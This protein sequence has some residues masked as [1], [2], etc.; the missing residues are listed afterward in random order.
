MKRL[1]I[2]I[3]IFIFI[4]VLGRSLI[5]SNQVSSWEKPLQ[6]AVYPI[7]IDNDK[8]TSQYIR[9]LKQKRFQ[10]IERFLSKE[11]KRYQQKSFQPV[12]FNM[13]P[14]LKESPPPAPRK[15]NVF[16]IMW[17][18]L[19]MRYWMHQLESEYDMFPA[20]ISVFVQYYNPKKHPILEHSVGLKKGMFSIIHAYASKKYGA[21]NNVI[22]AH[23][24]LHTVGATDKY[25][26]S[27]G[28]PSYPSGYAQPDKKPLHPQKI[29]ELMG[30]MIPLSE[31]KYIM[32][33]GLK[34]CLIG[35]QT[36]TE[37]GWK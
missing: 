29:A 9:Q 33:K 35:K 19:K 20:H 18:S 24:L 3:L 22:I 2:L 23:E 16:Q 5:T 28:Q 17:W 30:G 10:P 14:E 25:D 34:F 31:H 4:L 36:A 11:F 1:R 12:E 15:R 7:N 21:N 6:V 37:I 13:G 27:S 8:K 26:L 32:P